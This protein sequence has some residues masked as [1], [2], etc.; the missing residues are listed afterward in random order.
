VGIV[1][2]FESVSAH[3]S[4]APVTVG[5]CPYAELKHTWRHRRGKLEF[6]I[7]D[8]VRNAPE[9]VN[10]SLAWYLLCRAARTDCPDGRSSAYLA[11]ARSKEFWLNNRD[12][13]LS[14]ARNLAVG[15]KGEAR[16]LRTVFDYVNSNYFSGALR[17]P[18]LA[19][20][21]ESPRHRLGFYFEPLN[22]LAANSVLDSEQVPR[23]VLEFVV[24]HELLHHVDA[25]DGKQLR[26]VHHTKRFREQERAFS[27]YGD[28][29][30]WLR[31]LAYKNR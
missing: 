19:W 5:Y 22:L 1:E 23:Y 13:Y 2:S 15:P 3:L 28:A 24:Y 30:R 10:D 17:D 29:E 4:L 26:R 14:R 31:R 8:Y 6:K 12:M 9:D 25:A 27:A 7:S 11:F 18:I 21:S 20:S 16:D